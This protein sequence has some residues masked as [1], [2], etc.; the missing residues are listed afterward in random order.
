MALRLLGVAGFSPDPERHRE[1]IFEADSPGATADLLPDPAW[2]AFRGE[3]ISRVGERPNGTPV[4]PGY[5]P[6][7]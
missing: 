6:V 3:R 4:Y 7:T 2:P 1:T 5:F